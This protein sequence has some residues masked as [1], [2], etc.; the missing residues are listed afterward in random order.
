MKFNYRQE[1]LVLPGAALSHSGE[2]DANALRVLLWLSSDPVLAEKPERLGALAG[3]DTSAAKS[4]VLFWKKRGILT[5]EAESVPVMVQAVP[6]EEKVPKCEPIRRAETL[7]TYTATEIAELMEQRSE[8]R[9]MIDEAQQ[10]LGKMFNP[11]DLNILIGMTDYLGMEGECVLLLLAHC[12]R[13]GKTNLRA[14]EKYAFTLAE[15]DITAPDAL[16]ERIREIEA[17]H[18][19][20][21]QIRTMFGLKSRSL[22][23]KEQKMLKSWSAFGYS[24]GIVRRSYELTVNATGE[25][26]LAYANAILERWHADGL[27]SE[28]DIDRQLAEDAAK[29]AGKNPKM[30]N[31]GTDDYFEAALRRSFR[32]DGNS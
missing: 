7:P 23:T 3:C 22:T 10:I 9:V 6:T 19:F 24:E 16:E 30:T 26:S 8:M 14:I 31:S 25:P 32:D 20:E 21:G 11:S 15:S 18:S 2:A 4:A 27:T 5:G 29:K 17:Y 28:T 1:V 13:M 12:K